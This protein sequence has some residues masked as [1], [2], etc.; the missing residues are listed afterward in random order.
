MTS[1]AHYTECVLWGILSVSY[2]EGAV[3]L[4]G[5][6]PRWYAVRPFWKSALQDTPTLPIKMMRVRQ[7]GTNNLS[8]TISDALGASK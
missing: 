6:S 2:G 1:I 5:D 4:R 3:T 7:N 8:P